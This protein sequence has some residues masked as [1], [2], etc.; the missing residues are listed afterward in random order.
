M[1]ELTVADG[2]AEVVLNAPEKLNALDPA[3]TRRAVRRVRGGG[4]PG[5]DR[6]GARP[7]AARRGPRVLRRARHLGR[8]P[9]RGRRARL[10]RRAR[11]AAP[12]AHGVPPG[13]DVRGRARR[14]PRRG[15][16]PAHRERHRVRRRH[17]EDRLAVREPRRDPRLGRPRPLRRAARRAPHHGPHRHRPAHV[18]HRGGGLRPVLAGL[19]RRR[20]D[21]CR[22]RG[23]PR[24]GIR[25]NPGVRRVE[26]AR[27]LA[28]RRAASGSGSR[29]TRRTAPRPRSATPTTT[30]RASPPSSRSASRSS[31]AAAESRAP[32]RLL[33]P[34]LPT[35]LA[36]S[37]AQR[38]RQGSVQAHD[39]GGASPGGVL[40]PRMAVLRYFGTS[41]LRYFGTSPYRLL[42]A[43]VSSSAE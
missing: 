8:R 10:P 1:I 40:G 16:R 14:L 25:S 12:R 23:G 20:G 28:P 27:R 31:P 33:R 35:P 21:G 24:R 4:A 26:G 41:V 6:R 32:P 30:A 43:E 42:G 15:A 13:A 38:P 17:R 37:R 18:G 36:S 3:G 11:A 5:G 7:R 39:R 19:P 2:V 9:A 29:W 22:P 34:V